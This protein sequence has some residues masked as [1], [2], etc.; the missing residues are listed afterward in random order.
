MAVADDGRG[1]PPGFNLE[2]DR[3]LGLSIVRNL[4][5]RNLEGSVAIAPRDDGP[6][7]VATL[8]FAP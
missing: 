1:L 2:S 6:G 7:A 5:E 3:G 8:R 4:S